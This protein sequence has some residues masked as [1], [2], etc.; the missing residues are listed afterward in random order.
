MSSRAAIA[1]CLA[2]SALASALACASRRAE[3]R[4]SQ[5]IARERDW[6]SPRHREHPLVGRIWDARRGQWIDDAALRAAAAGAPF[7]VLGETHD[8]PD[9]H[10]LQARL[11]RAVA[12]AGR[13]P[14]LAFEM[15][16]LDDQPAV[17]AAL[18]KSPRDAG[19]LG[20]AV[21]WDESG[22]P[23][24][25]LYRPIVEAGLAAGMPIVAANLARPLVRD[26]VRKGPEVL[27]ADLRARLDRAGPPTE[28]E[29]K[30]LR[31]EMQESHCGELPESI[32]D[33]MVFAQR[34]RDAQMAARM[35][36]AGSG[37]GAILITGSGHARRD[38]AVPAFLEREAPGRGAVVVAFL[39]ATASAQSPGDYAKQFY[40]GAMPFDFVVFTPAEEREDPCAGFRE[41]QR[42]KQQEAAPKA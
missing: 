16:D 40:A 19:L 41:H 6:V 15:L 14:A 26:V 1:A 29:R 31:A 21:G 34:V 32:L 38:R 27:P 12:A 30:A 8:N 39:E 33:S 35:L 42:R 25:R 10:L 36:D 13:R 9:H 5:P 37:D 4:V 24:F 22:W 20:H 17:D 28:E 7:L 11:V 23:E 2:A 3:A 18:A